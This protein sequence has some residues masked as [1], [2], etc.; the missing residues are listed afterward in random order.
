MIHLNDI[1]GASQRT[2]ECARMC[3]TAFTGMLVGA[4]FGIA[5]GGGVEAIGKLWANRGLIYGFDTFTGHP[6]EV[7]DRC[8]Y[9]QA[10]GGRSSFAARCM[11]EWYKPDRFGTE[12]LTYEYQRAELDRQ[13]LHNVILVKGMVDD[14]TS[15]SY[16]PRLHYCLLDLDYPLSMWQAYNLVKNKMVPGG[17][18]CLHDVIPPGHIPGCNEVYQRILAEDLFAVHL[19]HPAP[20]HLV[21]MQKK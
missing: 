17:Y 5:Y 16:I 19:E 2:I 20:V 15:I 21:I 3:L 12:A 7:A 9:T 8:E 13:G 4:E 14:T 6:Q 18:L 11:D 1:N 10:A